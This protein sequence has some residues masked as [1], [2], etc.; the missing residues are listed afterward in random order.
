VATP[1]PGRWE[2]I[3]RVLDAALELA[4]TQRAAYLDGVCARDA[5]LR[6]EVEQML[7]ACVDAEHLLDAPL[8]A[9]AAPLLAELDS[10]AR[11]G[12]SEDAPD[13]RTPAGMRVGAYRVVREIGR[14]GMGVVYLA[15]RDD[16][17]YRK[18]V[19]V[20]LVR[21]RP[22]MG[23][24]LVSRFREER[25]ILASL[26]HPA[27]VRLLDGGV[28]TDGA[29]WF[30]MEYVEGEPIDKHCDARRLDLEARLELFCRASE[31][32]E[33]AHRNRIVHRDLKP[34]NVLVNSSGDVKLLD[35]G[36]A[37][38]L[39]ADGAAGGPGTTRPGARF[40]TPEYAS[41]EQ[42]RGEPVSA[43]GDVYALGVLLYQLITGRHP[44]YL[45]GRTDLEIQRLV[46][47]RQPDRP[48]AAVL[49]AVGWEPSAPE[50][51]A[52]AR[53]TTPARLSR[54]LRGDLD[55]V[56][57]MAL[58][59]EPERRYAT[60]GEFAADVRRHLAGLPVRARGGSRVYWLRSFARRHAVGLAGWA[61]A[62]G[63]ALLLGRSAATRDRN[64]APVD[65]SAST[66]AV[67]PFVPAHADTALQRLGRDLVV[68]VSASL[69]RIDDI[70]TVDALTIL[71]G[72][73]T[74]GAAL[75]VDLALARRLGASG[76]VRGS[77][78]RVGALV[79]VDATL[80]PTGGGV[81]TARATVVA[82]PTDLAALT[83]SVTWALLRQVWRTR[84]PPV[85][86]LAA[87]TTHS[88][89]ALRAF[90]DGERLMTQDRYVAAADAFDRA[91]REDSTF[92]FAYWRQAYARYRLENPQVDSGTVAAY[93]THRAEFPER[94]RLMIEAGMTDSVSVY[95]ARA[96]AVAE[97]FPDY[98]PAQWDY[99][100][101]LVHHGALFGIPRARVRAA[102]ERTLALNPGLSQGWTHMFWLACADADTLA[103]G[104]SVEEWKRLRSRPDAGGLF[105]LPFDR[106]IELL[107]RTDGVPVPSLADSLA[108]QVF[109]AR[110]FVNPDFLDSGFS[111]YGLHAAQLDLSTRVL[112]YPLPVNLA[113][114]FQR[115]VALSWAGRGAWDSALVVMGRY[116]GAAPDPEAALHVYRLAVIGRWLGA[117]DA[118]PVRA[119]RGVVARTAS[120]LPASRR[121]EL[122]WLDGLAAYA[123]EDRWA[124]RAARRR[125][126]SAD[127]VTAA[128]LDRSL[129][130]FELALAGRP[131]AAAHAL[132]VL[133][134]E[135]AD[136]W[137]RR[138]LSDRHAYL[139]AVDR[140]VASRLLR[141]GGDVAGAAQ[142]LVFHEAVLWPAPQT[143]HANDMLAGLVYL[144]RAR[145]EEQLARPGVARA[146]YQQFLRRYDRAVPRHRHLVEEARAALARLPRPATAP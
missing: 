38:L 102:L 76:A 47:E 29:P 131:A 20:K 70:R 118:A 124:L 106:Y 110:A 62:A 44:Y 103:C 21:P 49:S 86:N 90:V 99:A 26:E 122:A 17:E 64:A 127:S 27:I 13:A 45:A 88:V 65:P 35:F 63:G 58:R 40:V 92:W 136:V 109:D 143:T 52:E 93:L 55:R 37:R 133:E 9:V 74:E 130:A 78:T 80:F 4:P 145:L 72:A 28:T 125:L 1:S 31:A 83:D 56:A 50:R 128:I 71:A 14:G 111:G 97:R 117:V 59:K 6:R 119:W 66:L 33:H 115:S 48:S 22:G 105:D 79:R 142:L 81:P 36:I 24:A 114:F 10:A 101:A 112:R 141:S 144:E 23:E 7:R 129:G 8:S 91:V 96:R 25:Q 135:R 138:R 85:P 89:A 113:A 123:A 19:A 87:V 69:D 132:V 82:A 46:V 75:G 42:L 5:D 54:R 77:L 146:Y 100:N 68:T 98:W 41:P 84:T 120:Q 11:G 30:A 61:V 57:L 94:D 107:T 104:R 16:G 18:Q 32:V 134:R 140:M 12:V 137:P 53:R 116:A 126:A 73:N 95:L 3:E 121:A 43:P 139:S 34:S 15:E 51:L 2:E 67:L 60:A 39:P 108:R